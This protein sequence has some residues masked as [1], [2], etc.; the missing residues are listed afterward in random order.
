MV[1][2]LV[3]VVLLAR[4]KKSMNSKLPFGTFLSAATV[5]CLFWGN[6]LI[7]WYLGLFGL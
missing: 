1:G 5:V 2:A 4:G 3:G 7:S 6:Q